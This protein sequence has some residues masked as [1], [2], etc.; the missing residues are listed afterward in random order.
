MESDQS[1]TLIVFFPNR[2]QTLAALQLKTLGAPKV[3]IC[4]SFASSVILKHRAAI[5]A[6][7]PPML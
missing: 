2:L 6:T 5:L 4:K 1:T 3:A 7:A